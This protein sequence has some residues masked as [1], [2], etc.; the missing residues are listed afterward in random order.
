MKAF[1]TTAGAYSPINTAVAKELIV[2]RS[3]S[4]CTVLEKKDLLLC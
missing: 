2:S 1:I 3:A 4:N